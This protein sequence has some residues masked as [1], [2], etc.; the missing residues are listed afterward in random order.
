MFL[1]VAVTETTVTFSA[2]ENLGGWQLVDTVV[3]PE[4]SA[5]ALLGLGLLGFV[6]GVWLVATASEERGAGPR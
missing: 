5:I 2:Y 6:V 1:D 4:P 3:V